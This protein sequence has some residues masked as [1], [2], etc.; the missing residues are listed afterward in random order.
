MEEWFRAGAC[1]GFNIQPAYMPGAFED[2]VELVVP[3]LRKRGLIREEY[4]GKTLRDYFGLPR[5]ASRYAKA[6]EPA[7]T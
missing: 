5:P 2:F 1:D 4:E 3:E 7:L 6:R